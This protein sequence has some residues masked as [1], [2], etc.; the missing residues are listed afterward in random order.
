MHV[1]DHVREDLKR[2][3]NVVGVGIGPKRRGGESTGEEAVVVF[4]TEKL[5]ESELDPDDVCPQ[6]VALDDE[7]VPTDVVES[8]EVRFLDAAE[9]DRRS[10]DEGDRTRRFR[11]APASVSVGHPEV[12][13]GTLGSPPLETP[14][15][16]H[17]FLTNAHVA[18]PLGAEPGDPCLQPGPADGGTP[19]DE[20]GVLHEATDISPDGKN[21]SDSA[22]VAV[23]EG[24]MRANEILGVG[25]LAGWAEPSFDDVFR[26]SGRTTGVTEGELLA[27]DVEVDVAGF[28]P[29]ADATFA[30]VDA[31][32]SMADG[33]DSGSLIGVDAQ[34]GFRATD[35]LFAGSPRVTFGVPAT[36]VRDEHGDLAVAHPPGAGDGPDEERGGH[37]ALLFQI[38]AAL[39]R[40]LSRLA[41]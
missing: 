13:A 19:D 7:E 27:R 4:V 10:R 32:S 6:T 35:L 1:P 24:A 8:G 2:R 5:P 37:R 11:P 28:H 31:F 26:K 36:A 20:I 41:P 12:T 21:A 39:R 38:L 40:L 14:D 3:A 23:E 16:E 33:G 29:D 34:A 9:G 15:G 17:V 30:G 18:A 22:L 25:P